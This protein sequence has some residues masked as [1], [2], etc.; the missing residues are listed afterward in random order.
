MK[1]FSS[2]AGDLLKSCAV[3][4]IAYSI[5]FQIIERT[6]MIEKVMTL[7]FSWWELLIITAFIASRLAAYLLVP[8]ALLAL[9]TWKLTKRLT[10][11]S[12]E[13]PAV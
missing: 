11:R 6:R 9:M 13:K 10:R 12:M 2:N 1:Y 5:L 3:V 4:V 7:T 8:A